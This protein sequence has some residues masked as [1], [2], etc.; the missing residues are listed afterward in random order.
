[1]DGLR[2]LK[3]PSELISSFFTSQPLSMLVLSPARSPYSEKMVS[4]VLGWHGQSSVYSGCFNFSK[5]QWVNYHWLQRPWLGPQTCGNKHLGTNHNILTGQEWVI[6][7]FGNVPKS[8]GLK[9]DDMQ[10]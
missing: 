2:D 4:A 5:S 3:I 1:M 9:T 10:F 6:P 8:H 7:S